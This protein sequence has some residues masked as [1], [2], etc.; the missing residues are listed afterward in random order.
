MM[1]SC[2][3]TAAVKEADS[4]W[5]ICDVPRIATYGF[6]IIFNDGSS[7]SPDMYIN[8]SDADGNVWVYD[9]TIYDTRE[10]AENAITL[11]N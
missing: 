8:S 3:K 11:V 6:N 4:D 7:Q 2:D 1:A 10:A 9:G 5:W